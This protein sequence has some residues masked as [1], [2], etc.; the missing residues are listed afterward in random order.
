MSD[1]LLSDNLDLVFQNGDFVIDESQAQQIKLCLLTAKGEWRE[2]PTIGVGLDSYL[3][4]ENTQ[5]DL[6]AEIRKQ[7]EGDGA[8]V[9]SVLLSTNN[10]NINVSV[11]AKWQQ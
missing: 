5:L 3:V 1:I 9:E 2:N 10:N 11:N 6:S 4:G 7:L 8:T